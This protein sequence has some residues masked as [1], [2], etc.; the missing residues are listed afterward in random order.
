M[1][2]FS[3]GYPVLAAA[4]LTRGKR[5]R[6]S[7][8][9]FRVNLRQDR[10]EVL[11]SVARV[12]EPPAEVYEALVISVR[13]YVRKNGFRDVV[14]GLSGGVDSALT[15]VIAADALGANNVTAVLMPTRFSSEHSLEDARKLAKNLNIRHVIVSIDDTFQSFLE[16]LKP[17]FDGLPRELTAENLQPRIRGTLLMA[18]SNE[19]GS[20]VLTTGNKSETAVGYSTLYGD[21][22]GGFAVLKDVRKTLV[23]ELCQYRNDRAGYDLVPER[24]L[25]KAPS[26]ELR[27]DQKDSDSLPEYSVLDP[28]L[29]AYVEDNHS[30][31][32]MVQKGFASDAVS[33][34]VSL[35]DRNEYKRRQSPPG[36]KITPR[37]FGKDWRLPI[38]NG[39]R[40]VVSQTAAHT[41]TQNSRSES[42]QAPHRTSALILESA[43][44]FERVDQQ[45]VNNG[46]KD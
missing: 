4:R 18:L 32:E 21:T 42:G 30:P 31:A 2:S 34:T 40:T 14:L 25:T 43:L 17:V 39:Y 6:S 27:P 5:E 44:P 1:S 26:A 22:A 38:T 16:M 15:A 20:L 11:P 45:F 12:Y 7:G 29:K 33:R 41:V 3:G 46:R 28:I 23:Y 8:S 24:T 19:L 36:V 37:A 9:R 13:D 10:K 35:V